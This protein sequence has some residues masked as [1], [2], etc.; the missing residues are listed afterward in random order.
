MVKI[1]HVNIETPLSLSDAQTTVLIIENPSEYYK[2]VSELLSEFEEGGGNYIFSLDEKPVSP[3]SIGDMIADIFDFEFNDR[4]I[5][6][7]L[8][9]YLESHYLG[10]DGIIAFNRATGAIGEFFENL[11]VPSDFALE[12]NELQPSDLFKACSVK[13]SKTY[14]TLLEKI[15]CYINILVE[16]KRSK[17]VIFVGLRSVLTDEELTV[18]YEHCEREHIGILLIESTKVRPLLPRESAVIITQDLCE[19]LENFPDM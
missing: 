18:L 16:L 3:S 12:Y 9:K 19:I 10:G 14:D 5:I 17:F 13:F 8:Y 2:T 7:L 6:N 4:K 11:F 15:I 1:V